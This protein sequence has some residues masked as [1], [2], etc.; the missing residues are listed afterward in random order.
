M[1]G[2]KNPE[3]RIRTASDGLISSCGMAKERISEFQP[4]EFKDRS[5]KTSQSKM[6]RRKKE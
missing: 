5:T 1:L 3:T 6:Q 2:I 4:L